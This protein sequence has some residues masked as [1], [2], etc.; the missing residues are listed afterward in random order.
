MTAVSTPVTPYPHLSSPFHA[1]APVTQVFANIAPFEPW[2]YLYADGTVAYI[3]APGTAHDRFHN[4]IDYGVLCG[5]QLFSPA[6]GQVIFAGHDLSGFGQ[7]LKIQHGAVITLYGHL[8]E[9]S[10]AAGAHVS[11]G[12]PIALTGG[13]M[14]DWRDGNSTGCHLHFSC[15]DSQSGHYRDPEIYFGTVIEVAFTAKAAK[16]PLAFY[17]GPSTATRHMY[18]SRATVGEELTFNGWMR[19]EAQTDVSLGTPDNRWYRRAQAN[20]GWTASAWLDGN[21]PNSTA[22]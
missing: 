14:G 22:Q 9:I 8:S 3:A 21:A 4:G 12:Q 16:V 5:T 10:V 11:A 19:G 7:C 20:T 2:G 13:G 15:I 17:Q 6:D 1:A 18:D